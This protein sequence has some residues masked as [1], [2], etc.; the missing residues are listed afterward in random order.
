MI[1][2]AV[3]VDGVVHGYHS[4][5]E[6]Y[7]HPISALVVESLYEGYHKVFSPRGDRRFRLDRERF[8]RVDADLLGGAVFG[9]SQTDFC[10]YHDKAGSAR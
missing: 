9:E 8:A 7:T 10:V 1:E 2:D 6:S 5:P 4:P 3:V